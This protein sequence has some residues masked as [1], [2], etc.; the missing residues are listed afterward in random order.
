MALDLHCHFDGGNQADSRLY[1]HFTLTAVSGVPRQWQRLEHEWDR[2]CTKHHISY[3]HATEHKKYLDLM[4]D[5]AVTAYENAYQIR[6]QFSPGL[7]TF[8]ATVPL[9]DHKRAC[10]DNPLVPRNVDEIL[11]R[12][13]TYRCVEWG[14][15]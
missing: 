2:K 6:P 11:L 8:S 10:A 3:F 9:K 4:E 13:V 7:Y 15:E 1:D 5:F 12:E 14:R